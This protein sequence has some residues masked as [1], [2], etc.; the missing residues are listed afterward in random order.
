MNSARAQNPQSSTVPTSVRST[1]GSQTSP[2]SSNRS[3]DYMQRNRTED[4]IPPVD[5]SPI[6][7]IR[8]SDCIIT[9]RDPHFQIGKSFAGECIIDLINGCTPTNVKVEFSFKVQII[10]SAG[11]RDDSCNQKFTG[12]IDLNKAKQRVEVSGILPK[13]NSYPPNGTKVRY[14]LVA[15]HGQAEAQ[16]ISPPYEFIIDETCKESRINEPEERKVVIRG[17]FGELLAGAEYLLCEDGKLMKKGYL[18]NDSE[19]KYTAKPCSIY[20]LCLLNSG[21]YSVERLGS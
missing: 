10:D 1:Q 11:E 21:P 18:S 17:A 9:T 13:S 20:E 15:Y 14:H 4:P 8:I 16:A 19:L 2:T 3:S 6:P 12:Y 7:G 5:R